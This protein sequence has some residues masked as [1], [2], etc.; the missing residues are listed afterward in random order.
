MVQAMYVIFENMVFTKLVVYIGDIIIFSDTP[1]K[2]LA[3]LRKVLQPLLGEKFWLHASKCQFS[4]K[5]LNI[6]GDILTLDGLHMDP[7][8]PNKVLEFKVLSNQRE[9]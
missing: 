8:K 3:T 4:T 5:S 9:L 7:K 6:L 1:D 2:H